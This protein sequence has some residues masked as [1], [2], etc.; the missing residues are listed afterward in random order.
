MIKKISFVY[1]L[2]FKLC[3]VA[4]LWASTLCIDVGATNIKATIF[5]KPITLENL[6]ENKV[7]LIPSDTWLSEKLP[8]LVDKS[9]PESIPSILNKDFDRISICLPGIVIN[10]TF[11]IRLNQPKIPFMIK[12]KMEEASLMP[13]WVENDAL[14]WMHGVL[15]WNDL[16]KNETLYPSLCVILGTGIGLAIAYTADYI[17]NF[18]ILLEHIE[19]DNLRKIAAEQTD[20]LFFPALSAHMSLGKDFFL[21]IREKHPDWDETMIKTVYIKRISAF[22]EDIFKHLGKKQIALK[23]VT[24]TGGFSNLLDKNLTF[25]KSIVHVLNDRKIYPYHNSVNIIPLLGC[26][27]Q[28]SNF[29]K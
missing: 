24:I 19:Y 12:Q 26:E 20:F 22:L 28:S 3:F 7:V 15:S 5:K 13:V 9:F 29:E 21:W 18:E 16:T 8:F 6:N 23:S 2:I 1:I 4:N 27:K 14:N 25:E 10:N 17:E 11:F